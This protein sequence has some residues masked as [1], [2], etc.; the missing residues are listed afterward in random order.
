MGAIGADLHRP[1]F[2]ALLADAYRNAG[3]I[4]EG[5]TLLDEAL[6]VVSHNGEALNEAE[7]WR[8]KGECCCDG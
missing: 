5:L 7:L 4:T 8:L 3:K 6:D 1:Y 2:L